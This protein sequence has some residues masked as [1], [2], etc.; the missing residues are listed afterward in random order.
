MNQQRTTNEQHDGHRNLGNDERAANAMARVL[1]RSTSVSRWRDCWIAGI[2]PN[3][4]G[5]ERDSHGKRQDRAVDPDLIETGRVRAAGQIASIEAGAST[6]S[7]ATPPKAT[8]SRL[9]RRGATAGRSRSATADQAAARRTD[10]T[11]NRQ[12]TLALRCERA[13][14]WRR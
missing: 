14:G 1:S 7:R 2:S 6:R 4:T 8:T 5:D 13:E 12:F 10:R 3:S 9:R 11:T